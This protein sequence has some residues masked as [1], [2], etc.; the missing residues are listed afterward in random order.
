MIS[1]SLLKQSNPYLLLEQ[2]NCQTL[3]EVFYTLCKISRQKVK[4]TVNNTD[5]EE[6]IETKSKITTNES[7]ITD[8]KQLIERKGIKLNRIKANLYKSYLQFKRSYISLILYLSFNI[9]IIALGKVVVRIPTD[10]PIGLINNDLGN[11]STDFIGLIDT[12]RIKLN[13][14][15][16]FESGIN[17]VKKRS[18]FALIQFKQNFSQEFETFVYDLNYFLDEDRVDNQLRLYVDNSDLLSFYII[19]SLSSTVSQLSDKLEPKYGLNLVKFFNTIT[20]KEIF[21]GD[22]IV[23]NTIIF[24]LLLIV[25]Y[26]FCGSALISLY[27]IFF[28]LTNN[29]IE[30]YL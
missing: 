9:V 26:T 30:R 7:S 24:I 14:F 2:Y 27:N 11:I 23:D 10:I 20:F 19:Q 22:F 17:S 18:N 29:S 6:D 3:E 1:G 15:D 8:E 5:I 28:E 25:S 16:S 4:I 21:Y 12:N 13:Y